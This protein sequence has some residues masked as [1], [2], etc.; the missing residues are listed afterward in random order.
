MIFPS[1]Q[2]AQHIDGNKYSYENT[3][4][5]GKNKNE[6]KLEFPQMHDSITAYHGENNNM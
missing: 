3:L 5:S 1:L 6:N 2:V 4:K